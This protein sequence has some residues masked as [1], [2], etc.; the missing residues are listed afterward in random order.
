MVQLIFVMVTVHPVLH[1]VMTESSKCDARPGM[2]WAARAL[3]RRSGKLRV[4]VCVD[5]TLSSLGRQAMRGTAARTMFVICGWCI[6]WQE[7]A[8]HSGV[9]DG[10]SLYGGSINI[11]CFEEDRGCKGIVVGGGWMTICIN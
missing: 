11:N 6:G 1:I 5:C 2:T 9:M 4:Q 3:V 7:V 10:P 8:N